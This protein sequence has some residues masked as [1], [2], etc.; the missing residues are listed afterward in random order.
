MANKAIQ[1]K[2]KSPLKIKKEIV[3]TDTKKV[4]PITLKIIDGV[5]KIN[6]SYKGGFDSFGIENMAML[7]LILHQVIS[8]SSEYN[9]TLAN[10]AIAMYQAL[11]PQDHYERLL[12]AQMIAVHNIAMDLSRRAMIPNQTDDA[13]NSYMNNTTK[14]M[15]TFTAQMEALNKYRT[16]GK[17][18]IQVQHVNVNE[19]G[20]ALVGNVN[21]GEG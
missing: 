9:E 20:Q 5:F 3:S 6:E 21:K 14:F 16:G 12:V 17:Q 1:T 4:N 13:H 11:E 19:G 18:T 2:T 15:R 10:G 8:S 7:R